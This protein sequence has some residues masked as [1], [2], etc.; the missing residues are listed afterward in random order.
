MGRKKNILSVDGYQDLF[1]EP[2]KEDKWDTIC[3]LCN[4]KFLK[5][6]DNCYLVDNKYVC[7]WECFFY[8]VTKFETEKEKLKESQPQR[9]RKSKSKVEE[10]EENDNN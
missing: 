2:I 7:S 5:T 10:A 1:S 8:N 4:R 6:E 3:P 9:G